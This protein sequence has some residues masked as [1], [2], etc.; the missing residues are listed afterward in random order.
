M[1]KLLLSIFFIAT[2]FSAYGQERH[3][4]DQPTP[5][6]VLLEE[7]TGIHCGYCPQGH[8]IAAAMETFHHEVSVIAVH[9]GYYADPNSDEPD[10][11]TAA[12]TYL[13]DHF[14]ISGYPSGLVSRHNFGTEAEPSYV[15]SR[16]TWSPWAKELMAETAEI[17]I[18]AQAQ[19]DGATK[20]LA[21]DVEGYYMNPEHEDVNTYRLN[22]AIVQSRILGPQNG[23]AMGNKYV[24]NHMLRMYVTPVKGEEVE[25][26]E[27]EPLFRKTYTVDMPDAIE[28]TPL[29]PLNIDVVVFFTREVEEVVN[30]TTAH[31]TY[32]NYAAAG[33]YELADNYIPYNKAYFAGDR[34]T[35]VATNLTPNPA[36]TLTVEATIDGETVA[37]DITF[38]EPLMPGARTTVDARLPKSLGEE[39]AIVTARIAKANGEE[40]SCEDVKIQA[41]KVAHC[42][43]AGQLIVRADRDWDE[44]TWRIYDLEGNVALDCGAVE[45]TGEE[46][47]FDVK[48]QDNTYYYIMVPDEWGNGVQNPRGKVKYVNTDGAMQVQ[49]LDIQDFGT[50]IYFKADAEKDPLSAV[51]GIKGDRN[52]KTERFAADGRELA[53]GSAAGLVI[54]RRGESARKVVNK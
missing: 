8:A 22:V 39:R 15:L 46:V 21:I 53:N 49:N 31:P 3:V 11:R 2:A 41:E 30:A 34:M 29:D 18:W 25:M 38:D 43:T 26:K 48:L 51:E 5:R 27:A 23:A 10:F 17:N 19:Y 4:S 54:E 7:F 37:T 44:N 14:G 33:K 50:R 32:T 36:A 45:Y 13:N 42:A 47:S 52:A 1:K 35:L 40:V 9:A 28:G 16:S 20:K 6:G 12:G 24:H